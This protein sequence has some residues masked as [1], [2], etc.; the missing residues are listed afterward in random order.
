MRYGTSADVY[1]LLCRK[2]AGT[3][4]AVLPQVANGT[5]HA[6][7][8]WLDAVVASLWPSRGLWLHGFEIKVRRDD[9]LQALREGQKAV[10]V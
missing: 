8:R 3:A 4:Y 2:F 7:G 1:A 5:G 9:W 6:A 10:A